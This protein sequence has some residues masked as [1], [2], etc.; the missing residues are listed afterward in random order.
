MPSDLNDAP[1]FNQFTEPVYFLGMP[2]D[3]SFILPEL[4][5]VSPAT[6]LKVTLKIYNQAN[7][8]LG[9]DIVS[10]VAAD[11]LEGFVCSLNIDE[12]TIPTGAYK[13]T[14]EIELT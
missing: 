5:E 11:E 6:L 13:M 4:A 14:A 1:F 10:Y 3:I 9:G 12:A 2:F 8:Q 7:A